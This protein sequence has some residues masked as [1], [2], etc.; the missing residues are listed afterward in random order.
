MIISRIL[1]G[2]DHCSYIDFKVDRSCVVRIYWLHGSSMN[3]NRASRVSSYCDSCW[4]SV[5]SFADLG[6]TKC[7]LVVE[8]LRRAFR[9]CQQELP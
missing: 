3:D 5:E 8:G 4:D 9:D 1:P 7:F 6:K 2:P